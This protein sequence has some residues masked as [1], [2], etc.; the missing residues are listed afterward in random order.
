MVG[1]SNVFDITA[2]KGFWC[3]VWAN[4]WLGFKTASWVVLRNEKSKLGHGNKKASW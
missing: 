4:C 1:L 3:G 2:V